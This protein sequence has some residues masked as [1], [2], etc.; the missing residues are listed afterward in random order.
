M[1]SHAPVSVHVFG[2]TKITS[3]VC[4][5]GNKPRLA[6][7]PYR[8]IAKGERKSAPR[9][10]RL[11]AADEGGGGTMSVFPVPLVAA[12]GV[13]HWAHTDK[14]ISELAHAAGDT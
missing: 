7:R 5:R 13:L 10:G 9:S 11:H 3:C 8:R 1:D 4:L 2:H 14:Q 6:T 12:D